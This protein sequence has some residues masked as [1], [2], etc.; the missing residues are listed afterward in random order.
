M[1]PS[2]CS[3]LVIWHSF[4]LSTYS[5]LRFSISARFLLRMPLLSTIVHSAGVAPDAKIKREHATF[6]A[7]VPIKAILTSD[8]FLPTIFS[9]LIKP[10][11]VTMAVPC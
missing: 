3:S 8:I 6:A 7:P 11:S 5:A 1:P 2:R 4:H 10:A 9:A